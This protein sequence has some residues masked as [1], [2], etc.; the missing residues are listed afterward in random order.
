M[1]R[2]AVLISFSGDGGVERMVTNLCAEFAKHVQVDLLAIKAGGG[3]ASRIPSSVNVIHL[4]ARHAWTSVPEIERYLRERRPD[5]LLVAKDRAGRAAIK[6]RRR[7]GLQMPL[8]I[9]LGTNLSAALERKDAFSRW[10]RVFPMR[11]LYPLASGVIAVS[12]GVKEDTQRVTGLPAERIVVIRNPVITPRLAE[13]AA[14]PVPHPWLADKTV[15]VIIGMGRLTRQKDFPTLL[16]AFAAL[17]PERPSRL[18]ILGEGR[19]RAVLEGL[20]R[21]LGVADELHLAGFQTNPYAWLARADLF[22]LSSAWEGS[23]NALTEAL[24]LG[25]PSVSTD[26]PSGPRE[27]LDGGRYGPLVPVGDVAAMTQAMR[28]TL[29]QPLPATELRAAVEEYR[30]QTSARRYLDLLGLP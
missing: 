14:E 3:H 1:K 20:A 16:R 19:D 28:Q 4:N 27:I 6:A 9:R 11:R 12:Q 15:P 5:A 24:A 22:V 13:Q 21:E 8:W 29:H 7:A 2:L 25:V 30:A 17:Q 26:C 23:P 18:I 10:L